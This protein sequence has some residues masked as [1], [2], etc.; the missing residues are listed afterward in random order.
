MKDYESYDQWSNPIRKTTQR[1]YISVPGHYYFET[2]YTKENTYRYSFSYDIQKKTFSP[3]VDLYYDGN[4]IYEVRYEY[5]YENNPREA[6]KTGKFIYTQTPRRKLEPIY[7][8]PSRNLS[9]QQGTLKVRMTDGTL[10]NTH[11][12]YGRNKDRICTK[13]GLVN[14]VWGHYKAHYLYN[15]QTREIIRS[16]YVLDT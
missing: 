6:V 10:M 1:V 3:L 9:M 15:Q 2:P 11:F 8:D 4:D 7:P 13:Y 14:G 5:V 16:M 12:H